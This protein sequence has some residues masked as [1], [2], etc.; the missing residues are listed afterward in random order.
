MARAVQ[1]PRLAIPGGSWVG[2]GQQC[3]ATAPAPEALPSKA[4][5]L[6]PN[7]NALR[8][9]AGAGLSPQQPPS[10][11]CP[12]RVS[13]VCMGPSVATPALPV[14]EGCPTYGHLG[15]AAC[16]SPGLARQATHWSTQVAVPAPRTL[17]GVGRPPAA[18]Q[19]VGQGDPGPLRQLL[20][21]PAWSK[22]SCA[23]HSRDG[24]RPPHSVWGLRG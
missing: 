12:A 11:P 21:S 4:G 13:T 2:R 20:A 1:S 24:Q 10:Q 19:V 22:C 16:R 8:T 23:R 7:R 14:P 6:T 15:R 5:A 9:L 3:P 17:S 18:E